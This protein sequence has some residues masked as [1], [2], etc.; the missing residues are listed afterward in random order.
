MTNMDSC[1]SD[2]ELCCF[3][4]NMAQ[5]GMWAAYRISLD[6]IMLCPPSST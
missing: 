3:N 5:S 1:H 6:N 2:D 4:A